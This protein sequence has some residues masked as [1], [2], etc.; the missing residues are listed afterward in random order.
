MSETGEYHQLDLD[1]WEAVKQAQGIDKGKNPIV[2][3]NG[4]VF[5][6][7]LRAGEEV[8]V[9]VKKIRSESNEKQ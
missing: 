8:R 2:M 6:G 7:K 4:T 5:V 9:F 3:K 1:V